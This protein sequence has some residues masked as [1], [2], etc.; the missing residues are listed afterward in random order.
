MLLL[1][2]EALAAGAE[3]PDIEFICPCSYSAASS[4]S[5]DVSLGLVNRGSTGTGEII[6]RAYAHT[7]LSYFDSE[8]REFLGNLKLT[9]NLAADSQ[10]DARSFQMRL[11]P[12]TEGSYYVTLLLLQDN[13]I[14]DVARTGSTVNFGN[15]PV[16]S[17]SDLYFVSDPSIELADGIVTL[18]FPGIGNS[19][20]LDETTEIALL[21]TTGEDFFTGNVV[22]IGEYTDVTNVDAGEQTEAATVQF[23]FNEDPD[24]PFYHLV[25]TDG[26]F[27]TLLHTVRAPGVDYDVPD[28]VAK[29]ADFLTDSDGDGVAD[30]NERL[31]GTNAGIGSSTPGKSYIDILAVHSSG[32]TSFYDGDPSARIDHLIAVSNAA[33][34]D[35][36][37][38][39]VFRLAGIQEV[40]MDT[41][42]N[43]HAWM[44]DAE[45]SAGVFTD[46]PALRDE[47]GADLVTMFRLYD[48]G[49]LCGL[50]T[51]GGFATEGLMSQS[52]HISASFIEFDEC[53]DLTMAHEIGHNMGL[54]HSSRQNETGTFIWSRGHG[55]DDDFATIM[56][57]ASEFRVFT[58]LPYFSNPRVTGCEGLPCGVS[59]ADGAHAAASLN[60]VRFQVAGFR[61]S[62]SE[63]SDGDGV[64]DTSDAFTS[65]ASESVDSD[66]DGLGDNA[67]Y[68][69][70]N[71]G[72]PDSYELAEG[73]DPFVDD[74]QGDINGNNLTNL[75]EYLAL[76]KATQYLQTNSDS[77]SVSQIHIVN[78][79]GET[80]IFTGSLYQSDGGRLG[81]GEQ[82]L[83]AEVEARGRLVLGSDDLEQIFGTSA[84]SGPA[85]LDVVGQNSF[86]VM[87]KLESPSGLVSNTNCVRENR[88]LNI[89]GFDSSNLTFAR[90]INTSNDVLS[91]VRGTLF[92]LDGEII[93]E[94]D[95]LLASQLAPKEQIWRN[96]NQIAELVGAEWQGEAMLEVN[97]SGGLK[98]LNLNFVNGETFFNFSC[99]ENSES[100]RIYLQTNS[101]SSS[102]SMTHI[103]NTDNA[104]QRFTGTIY[105]SSGSRMGAA[106]QPLHDGSVAPRGRLVLSSEMIEESFSIP[107]WSGPAM[108]EVRGGGTFELMTK[109]QSPSGL[110]SNTN[111]VREF[112]VHNIEG[113]DSPDTTFVRIINTG[114]QTLTDITGSLFDAA[115]VPIGDA[116][117]VLLGSL[118]PKQQVWLNR[119]QLSDVFGGWNGE[120]L[121][122]VDAGDELKL[123][124]LNFINNETFFNFSCYESS[125]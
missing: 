25:V 76:P 87:A 111:C 6:V 28:F 78:M 65:D 38:D 75:E 72:M 108:L 12:P 96:R 115:G 102:S 104:A 10:I 36:D 50:A 117:Q 85:I 18:E 114:D 110:V 71:D 48:N 13:F 29:G 67:D 60:A 32:V 61:Q 121:L 112:Q 7:A 103:V 83:G 70:D 3:G 15:S 66:G 33:L 20:T 101:T 118:D 1:G 41:T 116:S 63:D 69:D 53:G 122:T 125:D 99:F 59:G 31:A 45:T 113:S 47:T 19:G 97:V 84:W 35:S 62:T 74:A 100:G 106:D 88:L 43:I 42:Q 82:L 98:L 68:D 24:F 124:N 64:P 9:D 95:I 80:Q 26:Q 22:L 56:A 4:S 2:G 21:A 37:V 123:L 14:I 27:T 11:S 40:A 109:L 91:D 16:G 57:Y 17:F 93:G 8:D 58:E 34:E 90:L 30:D 86:A 49:G 51:L 81:A 92:D 120:A 46:L 55:V 105:D 94:P 107:P 73:L 52:E 77:A 39:I 23:S 54:G 89:E 44:D 5:V 119:N 79:S